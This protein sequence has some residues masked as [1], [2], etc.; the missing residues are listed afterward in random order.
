[1]ALP[2]NAILDRSEMLDL[3][4][5]DARFPHVSVDWLS[6]V[7]DDIYSAELRVCRDRSGCADE[8]F[9]DAWQQ[10]KLATQLYR[11]FD[12]IEQAARDLHVTCCICGEISLH[13]GHPLPMS[14]Q[15]HLAPRITVFE[16]FEDGE[17]HERFWGTP[18][19]CARCAVPFTRRRRKDDYWSENSTVWN[20]AL[21]E[22]AT[23]RDAK[24]RMEKNAGSWAKLRFDPRAPI[25]DYVHGR[26]A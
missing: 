23:N 12:T 26:A 10:G 3:L 14:L 9:F 2:D 18:P 24:K 20:D 8:A 7:L 11:A 22:L 17:K 5:Y 21:A 1:M 19:V 25:N 4:A 16:Y 6:G 15:S 13:C